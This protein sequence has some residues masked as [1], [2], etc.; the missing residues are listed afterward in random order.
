LA[1]SKNEAFASIRH[2]HLVEQLIEQLISKYKL[3]SLVQLSP[4]AF[5]DG[6][7]VQSAAAAFCMQIAS[8]GA[9]AGLPPVHLE[10]YGV[11]L[12]QAVSDFR[13]FCGISMCHASAWIYLLQ[14][15]AE[16]PPHDAP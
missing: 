2:L 10:S 15:V 3:W 13:V 11:I 12:C 7:L 14:R 9:N 4:S 8:S 6:R 16:D 1:P 5:V